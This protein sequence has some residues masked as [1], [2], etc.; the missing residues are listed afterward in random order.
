M[1]SVR[2][3]G[4][5]RRRSLPLALT[6]AAVAVIVIFALVLGLPGTQR[7]TAYA[8]TP[9]LL[10]IDGASNTEY[11]LQGANADLRLERL[12][13]LAAEQ[14]PLSGS[15]PIQE[16]TSL[17]WWLDIDEADATQ[18]RVV[19][20][21]TQ[22]FQPTEST[23]IVVRRGEPLV[24]GSEPEVPADGPITS[25]ET[26]KRDPH[27]ALDYPERLPTDTQRLREILLGPGSDCKAIEAYCL[28]GGLGT[29]NLSFVL[30]PELEAALIRT[31]IDNSDI[32]Y[33]GAG[34]DRLGRS[35]DVFAV[36]DPDE[37]SQYI[38][39]FD[40]ETGYFAGQETILLKPQADLKD[41]QV[42]AVV[43]FDTI[44]DR[45]LISPDKLPP[46]TPNRGSQ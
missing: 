46:R 9:P 31:L 40:R 39:L 44:T 38:L 11:P 37:I 19:P 26:F 8:T 10:R 28:M 16:V 4:R 14:E 3:P 32:V 1:G 6:A 13:Q 24:D 30:R 15:G 20:V 22:R 5:F 29:L 7:A 33:A 36:D 45:A 12:A 41:I 2:G 27:N 17:G 34:H 42:P 25:D 18:R 35:V 23:R 21:R 43:G